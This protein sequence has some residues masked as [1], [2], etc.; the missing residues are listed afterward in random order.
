METWIKYYSIKLTD[1]DM[2]FAIA[3][4]KIFFTGKAQHYC[5]HFFSTNVADLKFKSRK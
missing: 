3:L 4:S 5:K 1:P 2:F